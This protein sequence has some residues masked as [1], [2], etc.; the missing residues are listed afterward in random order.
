M[1][2]VHSHMKLDLTHMETLIAKVNTHGNPFSHFR[3]HTHGIHSSIFYITHM[4]THSSILG[5]L[6]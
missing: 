6:R 3:S 5:T 1:S 2:L 4:E